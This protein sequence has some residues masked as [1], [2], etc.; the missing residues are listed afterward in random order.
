MRPLGGLLLG[1]FSLACL[2]S[3]GC[4][5][6]IVPED[7]GSGGAPGSGSGSG[8]GDFGSKGVNVGSGPEP[9]PHLWTN[10]YGDAEDQHLAAFAV[11]P[12]GDVALAGSARGTV[13]FGNIPW[14]GGATDTDVVVAKLSTEG[15][16]LWS[17]RFGDS[18]D[19][20][21]GAIG[22]MPSGNVLV[23]GDFCGKMDFGTTGV[24]TGGAEVD[25]FVAVL[26]TL[27]EDVY[28]VRIGGK[29]AQIARAAAVDASGSAVIVGSFDE[30]FDDGAGEAVSAGMD[31]AFVIKLDPAGKVLW[32]RRFGG[33]EADVA[34]AVAMDETGTIVVG[35][36]FRGSVDFGGTPL[37]AGVGHGN[38]FVLAL[39]P[40]GQTLWSKSFGG[41][42]EAGVAGVAAGSAG[43]IAATG[44]FAGAADL[45]GGPAVS[46][47]ADDMFVTLMSSSGA[48][49]WASTFGG[50]QS[51]R[52]V[53]VTFVG[54]S[55][56][57]VASGSS[58][59]VLDFFPEGS[60]SPDYKPASWVG[61][62][63][64]YSLRIVAGKLIESW[65]MMSTAPLECVGLGYDES[66][67]TILAG[68]F[69][70][71]L[72]HPLGAL[73]SRGGWDMFVARHP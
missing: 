28:S 19:Q 18:C 1:A 58:D 39:D 27:G 22:L 50:Q 63:M 30:G 3:A 45:G 73:E 65:E 32:S 69:E 2:S 40:D 60:F 44:F 16:A 49:V 20:R 9:N 25:L 35:G 24:E 6:R 8:S 14:P 31:D 4:S 34:Q 7:P 57:V 12:A 52:G 21:A 48:P 29:G 67:A 72:D 33:P 56:V 61:P 13:D 68:S 53:G 36:S 23:A 42:G 38:G 43:K 59:E 55:E 41:D 37:T 26:D 54:A 15:Q 11:N 66:L 64:I 10:A 62:G 51:Q 46:V 17:R 5:Q 70:E 71:T 47:G